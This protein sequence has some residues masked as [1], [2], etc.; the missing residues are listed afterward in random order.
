MPHPNHHIAVQGHDS[1]TGTPDTPHKMDIFINHHDQ[2]DQVLLAPHI[3]MKLRHYCQVINSLIY[4]SCDPCSISGLGKSNGH[5]NNSKHSSITN[6]S[7]LE[8]PTTQNR[9]SNGGVRKKSYQ[10][11]IYDE[12]KIP[13]KKP[14]KVRFRVSIDEIGN[15][16]FRRFELDVLCDFNNLKL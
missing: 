10:S 2:K 6:D 7:V 9:K 1:K 3:L 15:C 8:N 4:W 13:F 5:A 12:D 11:Y 14:D 16:S